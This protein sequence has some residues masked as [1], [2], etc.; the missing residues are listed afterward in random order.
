[1]PRLQTKNM[2]RERFVRVV[3]MILDGFGRE[4]LRAFEGL[5]GSHSTKL[6]RLVHQACKSVK[7]P[8]PICPC[9]RDSRHMGW[10]AFRSQFKPV[11]Q[12]N[13]ARIHDRLEKS[14]ATNLPKPS[15]SRTVSSGR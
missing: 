14:R 12:A 8:G 10:C 11:I 3:N 7:L 5:G 1:M 2:E 9:G 4:E 6:V 13:R 15:T